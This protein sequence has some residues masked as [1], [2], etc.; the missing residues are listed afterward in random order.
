M[1][2]IFSYYFDEE[3]KHRLEC[4]FHPSSYTL[5]QGRNE[6]MFTA[7]IAEILDG[8]VVRSESKSGVFHFAATAQGHDI[9]FHRIRY[10]PDQ[11]WIF[12]IKN[13]KL[14][15]ENIV[16]GL[17]SETANKNPLGMDI[18]QPSDIY[19]AGLKGNNLAKLEQNY[20]PPV[21]S[22]TLIG[23]TFDSFEPPV[24]FESGTAIYD[25]AK[26]CYDLQDFQQ[27]FSSPIP[28]GAKFTIEL[29]I[30]PTRKSDVTPTLFMVDLKGIGILFI[31]Q[32][33]IIFVERTVQ[34]TLGFDIKPV[35]LLKLHNGIIFLPASK[36]KIDGDGNG[37]MTIAYNGKTLSTPYDSTQSLR[38]LLFESA[39]SN[40]G[41][42]E[43]L[44][45]NFFV[46][47]FK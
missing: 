29:N 14:A 38:Q 3:K 13:N 30:A 12:E 17:I 45:D 5:V 15:S 22:Q 26:K 24:G 23:T 39:T 32:D 21:I 7:K 9:D 6:M 25:E 4:S 41:A 28:A 1:F 40:S 8:E 36:L 16:I 18:V 35:D 46:T 33:E 10:A 43:A 34:R 44:I 27:T 37:N 20:K 31:T 11:K 2:M 19:D 42:I 47:Y